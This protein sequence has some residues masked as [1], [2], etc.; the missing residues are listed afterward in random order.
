MSTLN[1]CFFG[2]IRK[3]STFGLKKNALISAMII[4]LN[5]TER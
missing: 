4:D 5:Y 3:I 1:I 2:E